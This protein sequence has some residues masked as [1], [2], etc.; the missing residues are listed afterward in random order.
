MFDNTNCLSVIINKQFLLQRNEIEKNAN[1]S[2]ESRIDRCD[3][4]FSDEG[5]VHPARASLMLPFTSAKVQK[6]H[7]NVQGSVQYWECS[8]ACYK[9]LQYCSAKFSTTH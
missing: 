8:R 1:W 3:G 6:T 7:G 4:S 5:I 2:V 9:K